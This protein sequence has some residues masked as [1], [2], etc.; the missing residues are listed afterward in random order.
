MIIPH[1]DLLIV[2]RPDIASLILVHGASEIEIPIV[3]LFDRHSHELPFQTEVRRKLG[4]QR[5]P[6][7]LREQRPVAD[8]SLSRPFNL[9]AIQQEFSCRWVVNIEAEGTDMEG[10]KM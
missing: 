2:V 6:H 5:P 1:R 4:T 3:A 7:Q 10:R 8:V 9:A